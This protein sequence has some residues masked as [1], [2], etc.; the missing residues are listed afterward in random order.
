VVTGSHDCLACCVHSCIWHDLGLHVRHLCDACGGGG[1]M[2]LL[3]CSIPLGAAHMAYTTRTF[4]SWVGRC[5]VPCMA[6]TTNSF[7][8][9]LG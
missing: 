4:Y 1:G 3:L 6:R 8:S 7:F 2:W 9:M 5:R